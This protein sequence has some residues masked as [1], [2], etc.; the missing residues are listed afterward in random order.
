M[1]DNQQN[2]V[3]DA[4]GWIVLQGSNFNDE[5]GFPG[6]GRN[7]LWKVYNIQSFVILTNNYDR[8]WQKI[9]SHL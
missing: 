7:T 5:S 3:I 4:F 2:K 8:D 6:T 9:R 1:R